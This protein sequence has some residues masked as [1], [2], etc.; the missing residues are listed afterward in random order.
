MTELQQT[1][2]DRF[3]F[4]G[5]PPDMAAQLIERGAWLG[6]SDPFQED[7]AEI[8][9]YRAERDARVDQASGD[10]GTNP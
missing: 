8:R 5:Y 1:Q 6:I 4:A 7:V 2:Y 9:R 10:T 3:I